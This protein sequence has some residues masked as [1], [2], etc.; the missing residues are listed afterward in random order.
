MTASDRPDNFTS[1][2]FSRPAA[3]TIFLRAA[4]VCGF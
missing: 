2:L 1:R 3:R 4:W